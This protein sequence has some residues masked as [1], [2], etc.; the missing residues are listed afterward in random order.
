[1]DK[2][3]KLFYSQVQLLQKQL[4]SLLEKESLQKPQVIE[5]KKIFEASTDLSQIESL[6]MG[7]P[8]QTLSRVEMLFSRLSNYFDSGLLFR[9]DETLSWRAI[10]GFDQG[11][12]FPLKGVEL[13][14]PFKFPEMNLIEVR[15]VSSNDIFAHLKDIQVIK[16]DKSQALIFTPHPDF[17]FMVTSI[18]ADPWLKP[19]IERIQKEILMLLVDQF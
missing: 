15:K 1:M 12:Y 17:I 19:H 10:G 5:P 18:L 11:E 14:V 3:S 7:L 8:S 6:G 4:E 9:K 2:F 13:E 16:S